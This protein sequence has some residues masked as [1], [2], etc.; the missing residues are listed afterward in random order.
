MTKRSLFSFLTL[1]AVGAITLGMASMAHAAASTTAISLSSPTIVYGSAPTETFTVTVTGVAGDGKPTGTVTVTG[2]GSLGTLATITVGTNCTTVSN[3]E[4]SCTGTGAIPGTTTAGS[5]TI[6]AAYGGNGTYSASSGTAMLGVTRQTPGLGTVTASPSSVAY[7]ST[8]DVTFSVPL[9]WTG[10]GNAPGEP[11][12]FTVDGGTALVATCTGSS[13]PE[14]CSYTTYDPAALTV[15]SHTIAASMPIGG[16]Y[17]AATAT[18]GTL[19]VT[20]ATPT[21]HLDNGTATYGGTTTLTATNTGVAGGGAPTGSPTFSVN[22][23]TVSG[24]PSCTASGK[25]NTCTLSFT[26]PPALTAAPAAPYT[27]SVTFAA[28]SNYASSTDTANFTVTHATP[29]VAVTDVTRRFEKNV[30]LPATNTGVGT[31][32]DAPTGAPVYTINGIKARGD[33][34]L[35]CYRRCQF[36]HRDLQYAGHADRR[37]L[38]HLGQVCAG[39]QLSAGHGHRDLDRRG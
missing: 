15:G 17:A 10:S 7:A 37:D 3:H 26:G 29:T 9:S 27:S 23:V 25:V 5:Y 21:A 16:N 24:T 38:H 32:Y 8:A 4:Y 35:Y 18:S 39:Q 20:L 6:T 34:D 36:L 19:T 11:V 2:S 13:S 14:T 31:G 1:V 30:A 33:A 22:G 12:S 28:D